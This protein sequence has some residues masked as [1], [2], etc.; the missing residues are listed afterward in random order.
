MKDNTMAD[1]LKEL[2]SL[3]VNQ[4]T[5]EQIR[6]KAWEAKIYLHGVWLDLGVAIGYID[7]TVNAFAPDPSWQNGFPTDEIATPSTAQPPSASS[8]KPAST[9]TITNIEHIIDVAKKVISA[10]GFVYTDNIVSQLKSEGDTRPDS[11]MKKSI[12][13]ILARYGYERIDTGL[14]GLI[15]KEGQKE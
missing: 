11:D 2:A 12:G 3:T 4:A 6:E 14:Y 13:N 7:S 9:L 10:E 8:A 1:L 5:K 15:N